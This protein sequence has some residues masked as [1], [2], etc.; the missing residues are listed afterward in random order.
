M[1]DENAQHRA[2]IARYFVDENVEG[3]PTVV[4]SPSGRF[5]LTIRSYQIAP[6]RWNYSRG[7][8]T[9]A[10][11]GGTVCDIQRNY[12]V[13]H[14]S[15]V[16]KDG[17]E[18]LITGRSYM[19]QTIVDLDRGRELEPTGDHYNGGAFCWARC[20]LSPDG[21]T[22]AVDGCIWAC[23]YE[24][25][26]FDFTDPSKG[27]ASLPIVGTEQIEHPSDK[28]APVWIDASTFECFQ[29]DDNGEPQ[30]RTRVAR[31]GAEMVVV[32]H[33][34]SETEQKR[35]DDEVRAEAEHEAWWESFCS[36]DPRYQRL[37]ELVK[38]HR[39]P[40][41]D[42]HRRG[43]QLAVWFR[44]LEPHASADLAW[45]IDERRL[46]VQLYKVGGERD[47][48]VTFEP[49]LDGIEAAVALIAQNFK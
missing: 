39:L 23:P 10:A 20:Y 30:E 2:E 22:L 15:F 33:W 19:S 42:L 46:Q 41:D 49:T 5:R 24:F 14:H 6:G 27:W 35:R 12:A 1:A 7:T 4:M 16:T 21:N 45:D 43:H 8:V 34:V 31:R 18:Y 9:R 3:K 11:D 48:A 29:C 17:H 36:S 47:Q 25:C 37:V 26:F 13:F 28:R 38:R 44:R 40:Y 32:E